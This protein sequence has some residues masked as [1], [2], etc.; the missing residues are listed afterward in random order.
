MW[1]GNSLHASRTKAG[2]FTA[3]VPIITSFKPKAR[4]F[5]TVAK[6]RIPPPSCTGICADTSAKISSIA[7]KFFGSPAK[8]PSKSTKCKRRAPCFNQCSAISAGRSEN[9]VASS[10]SP[11]FRRTHWPFFKSIAGISNM[12]IR[13]SL[14]SVFRQAFKNACLKRKYNLA[15]FF[16]TE[17]SHILTY[18]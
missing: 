8:A 18:F 11:C 14:I 12:V 3:A 6:S 9:T 13:L 7:G 17:Y 16:N 1:P 15:A 5:S 2:F 4:Y 10:I